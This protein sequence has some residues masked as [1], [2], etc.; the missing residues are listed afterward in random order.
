MSII[1]ICGFINSGKGTVGDLLI[2]NYHF[3]KISFADRLKDTV[4]VLFDLPRDLLEG[5]TSE[6]RAWRE[7]PIE[8]WSN[9]LEK[10]ISPRLILQLV[11]TE[12]M[13]DGFYSDIWVL[14]VKQIILKNPQQNWVIPDVRFFNEQKMIKSLG[15][16]IWQ[17]R[18]GPLPNWFDDAIADNL[19]EGPAMAKHD[20][21][22]SEYKW[23]NHD[24]AFDQIIYNDSDLKD[25]KDQISQIFLV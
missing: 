10:E 23:I 15:G 17:I 1:G 22:P 11:G 4:S 20:I 25:L 13:R 3:K 7:K 6:S 2:Q 14:I 16:E 8:F 9:E 18:R 12:C 5:D 24:K 21:H 19:G